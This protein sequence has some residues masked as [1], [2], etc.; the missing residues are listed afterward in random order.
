VD[1]WSGSHSSFDDASL[2]AFSSLYAMMLQ[3]IAPLLIEAIARPPGLL[4]VRGII[5][6]LER[7]LES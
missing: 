5:D 2:L 1:L 4:D 3:W 7:A 6:D